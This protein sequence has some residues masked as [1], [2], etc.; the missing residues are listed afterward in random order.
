MKVE[1]LDNGTWV[2]L[3]KARVKMPMPGQY[4]VTISYDDFAGLS[5]LDNTTL[6]LNGNT[7]RIVIATGNKGTDVSGEVTFRVIL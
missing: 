1:I 2:H 4:E 7:P 6:R 5:E 3:P